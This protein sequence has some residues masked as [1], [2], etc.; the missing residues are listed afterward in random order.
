MFLAWRFPSTY[1]TLGCTETPVLP[2]IRVYFLPEF[3]PKFRTRKFCDVKSKMI[4]QT[5]PQLKCHG[6]TH[7]LLHTC[8]CDA[9]TPLL[10]FLVLVPTVVQQLTRFQLTQ[11]VAQS[12]LSSGASSYGKP[13]RHRLGWDG[14]CGNDRLSGCF[15]YTLLKTHVAM[16]LWSGLSS[17]G[18]LYFIFTMKCRPVRS[19]STVVFGCNWVIIDNQ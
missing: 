4:N 9:L 2:E 6:W 18:S 11:R 7:S 16:L 3:C 13:P 19:H 12:V 17:V 10:W 8:R 14:Q 1:F 15:P 5:R